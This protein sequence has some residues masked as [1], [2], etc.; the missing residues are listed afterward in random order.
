MNRNIVKILDKWFPD[1]SAGEKILILSPEKTS[2]FIYAIPKGSFLNIKGL[3]QG[4]AVKAGADK[5]CPVTIGIFLRMTIEKH[6]DDPNFL[7]GG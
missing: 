3:R 5:T 2:E 6:K 7:S 1:I 4:L